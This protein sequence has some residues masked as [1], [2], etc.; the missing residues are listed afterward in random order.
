MNAQSGT[1]HYGGEPIH[2]DVCYVERRTMEIAVHP[3]RKV[4]V[5][6]PVGTAW[7]DIET[8]VK[9]RV[10]W[11]CRQIS[12]F[13]QF[14]PRTPPRSYISGETHLYLGRHYRLK[15]VRGEKDDVKLMHG[16]VVVTTRNAASSEGIKA[17][18]EKWYRAKAWEKM[19]TIFD[20]VMTRFMRH[21]HDCPKLQ[22]RKMKT[23]WGSLSKKGALT[24]NLSLIRVPKECIE[25]VITHELCHL[26]FHDHSAGFHKLLEQMMP[27]WEKRKRRHHCQPI[28]HCRQP[29]AGFC[30]KAVQSL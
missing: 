18:L 30:K 6:A 12:H 19:P 17:L 9:K 26:M 11:I 10:R 7:A 27:E 3:D 29:V 14:E 20:S 25:Y 13:H 16:R 4:V 1:V 22:I 24:L 5:K 2:F 28:Q 15:V 21:G 8:R 23:R